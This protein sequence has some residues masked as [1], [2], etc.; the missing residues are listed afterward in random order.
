MIFFR[1]KIYTGID[2]GTSS[3]KVVQIKESHDLSFDCYVKNIQY[4]DKEDPTPHQVQEAFEELVKEMKRL[5]D[6]VT[7]GIQGI[8]V[9]T[10]Y[11]E[12][13]KIS[14]K[15]LEVALPIE[16]R[17]FLPFPL[18]EIDLKYD[19]IPPLSK[20]LK[21]M[22]VVFTG[23]PKV[24]QKKYHSMLKRSNVKSPLV[25][26]MSFALARGFK[27][28]NLYRRGETVMIVNI[29]SKYTNLTITR[30]GNVY[31]ARDIPLAGRNITRLLVTHETPEYRKAEV[32]KRTT[33]LFLKGDVHPMIQAFMEEWLG[34]IT[35]TIDF[36]TNYIVE[37]PQKVS[38]VIL[39]GGGSLLEGLDKF[40]SLRLKMPV[41]RDMHITGKLEDSSKADKI[42]KMGVLLKGAWGLALRSRE[43]RS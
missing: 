7:V 41:E 23:V 24:V 32:V 27:T 39:C 43:E 1:K 14:A 12:I 37:T 18:E 4:S 22:G 26:D 33:N 8:F 34:E 36:F 29:G 31:L 5:G 10:R 2:I 3:I 30:D 35:D 19:L 6:V 9:I 11:I 42:G 15:E 25:E 16:A 17:K 38:R 28:S 20:D 13:P 40:M 21:R